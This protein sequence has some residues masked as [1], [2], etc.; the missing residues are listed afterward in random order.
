MEETYWA[1]DRGDPEEGEDPR[2]DWDRRHSEELPFQ[3]LAHA[4][5]H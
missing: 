2:L 5:E 1:Q 4:H 3:A